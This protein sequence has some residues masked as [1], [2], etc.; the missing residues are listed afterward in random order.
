MVEGKK[1]GTAIDLRQP[2]DKPFNM[3]NPANYRFWELLD[4][5]VQEEPADSL[6]QIRKGYYASIGIKK[7]KP[8]APDARMKKILT[9]AA[10]V[11]DAMARTIAFHPRE[12]ETFY[13]PNSAWQLPFVGG[14]K[15][16]WRSEIIMAENAQVKRQ[17]V[18]LF[19]NASF[20]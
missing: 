2:L 5:V 11:G 18:I 12:P 8:F 6:D 3:E 17:T 7:G 15:F 19:N 13:N 20:L 10:R 16:Q 4:E 1:T 14:Y 9:E